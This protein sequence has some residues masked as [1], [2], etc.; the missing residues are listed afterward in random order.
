MPVFTAP[1][2]TWSAAVSLA[3]PFDLALETWPQDGVSLAYGPLTLTYAIPTRAEIETHNST[4]QQRMDT[5]GADYEARSILV[6]PEFPAWNLYPAGPW[7]YALCL[8]PETLKDLKVEWNDSCSDPLDPA[9]PALRLR[10]PARRVRGWQ[11]AHA[12]RIRQYGHWSENGKLAHGVRTVSG[13]F[14]FTPPLPD[15]MRLSER[16]QSE[17]EMIELIPYGASMLRVTVFPRVR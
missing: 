17:V 2:F 8:T 5:M 3:L 7:N 11:V 14:E 9:N 4:T 1:R 12:S 15:P 13:K 6:K 16:L 10:V